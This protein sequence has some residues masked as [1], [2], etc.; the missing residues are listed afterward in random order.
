MCRWNLLLFS[1]RGPSDLQLGCPRAASR[2]RP[3]GPCLR[4]PAAR[5]PRKD[6]S[7]S[8][9]PPHPLESVTYKRQRLD[10]RGQRL[11]FPS[12][13]AR[14]SPRPRRTAGLPPFQV[15]RVWDAAS[16]SGSGRAQ[17]AAG[18]GQAPTAAHPGD[19][20]QLVMSRDFTKHTGRRWT[21]CGRRRCWFGMF[22]LLVCVR[23]QRLEPRRQTPAAAAS[24]S[25]LPPPLHPPPPPPSPLPVPVPCRWP[26]PS[27]GG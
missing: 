9:G 24:F 17:G 26:L 16:E 19:G 11:P 20:N 25:P 3:P 12:E 14:R 2:R 15:R 27:L 10:P 7:T 21:R 13:A 18:L 5:L 23:A 6:S 8:Q 1:A 22:N 4:A